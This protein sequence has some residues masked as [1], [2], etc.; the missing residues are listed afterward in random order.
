ML[1]NGGAEASMEWIL[2]H[3]DDADLND[4]MP[5]ARAGS[6]IEQSYE[7]DPDSLAMLESMG[8]TQQQVS[9]HWSG[10]VSCL[11]PVMLCAVL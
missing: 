10:C 8:F 1:Q 9:C 5:E 3:L 11:M 2:S 7:A 4:P 6:G